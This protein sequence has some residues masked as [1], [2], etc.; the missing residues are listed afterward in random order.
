[1]DQAKGSGMVPGALMDPSASPSSTK[2]SLCEIGQVTRMPWASTFR[3]CKMGISI[4]LVMGIK[5]G[6][7]MW[8][9]R[10]RLLGSN[11]ALLWDIGEMS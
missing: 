10:A 3:L 8:W 6:N 5:W 2:D 4:A 11:P 1:M 7:E 9:G